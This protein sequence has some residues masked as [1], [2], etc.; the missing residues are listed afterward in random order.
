MQ[1]ARCESEPARGRLSLLVTAKRAD[2]RFDH[3]DQA[4]MHHLTPFDVNERIVSRS[5]T[6]SPVHHTP[7]CEGTGGQTP[8]NTGRREISEDFDLLIWPCKGSAAYLCPFRLVHTRQAACLPHVRSMT[9]ALRSAEQTHSP[10]STQQHIVVHFLKTA[11]N[12]SVEHGSVKHI[13]RDLIT[14]FSP[15]PTASEDWQDAH[16][17]PAMLQTPEAPRCVCS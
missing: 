6:F 8:H 13:N 5:E 1:L 15:G 4:L 14:A 7:A 3:A 12:P 11:G 10:P 17:L 9:Y 2:T 16:D